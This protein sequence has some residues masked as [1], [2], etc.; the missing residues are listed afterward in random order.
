MNNCPSCSGQLLRHSRRSG[1]YWFC[2]HCHQEMPNLS[3]IIAARCLNP[4][5][6]SEFS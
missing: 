6:K 1:I 5:A 3:A 4:I 2:S